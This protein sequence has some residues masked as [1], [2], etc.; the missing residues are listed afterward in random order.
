MIHYI[1]ET[2]V[3]LVWDETKSVNSL[4]LIF[5]LGYDDWEN[6]SIGDEHIVSMELY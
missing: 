6:W 1:L 4:L 5:L 3:Q 2:G